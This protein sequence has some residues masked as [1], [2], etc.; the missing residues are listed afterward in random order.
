MTWVLVLAIVVIAI[1][2]MVMLLGLISAAPQ[3]T[4]EEQAECIR[5]DYAERA[6][7]KK[8]RA[9]KKARRR[10]KWQS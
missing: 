4:M 3:E 10:A 5:K 8:A 2:F 9:D 7:R 1:L 6:A